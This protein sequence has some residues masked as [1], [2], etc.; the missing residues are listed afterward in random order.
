MESELIQRIEKAGQTHLLK[1][2]DEL[3]EQ[4]KQKYIETLKTID[5]ENITE[6]TKIQPQIK[7]D[8]KPF[9]NIESVKSEEKKVWEEKGFELLSQNKGAVLMLA[10]G[11][12][13]RLGF[14]HPKGMYD[15]GLPSHH[16]LFQLQTERLLTLQ[17]LVNRKFNTN[18]HIPLIIMTNESNENEIREYY[19]KNKYFGL[20]KD[21][22]YFFA[23]GML[24]AVDFNGKIIMEDKNVISLSPNG[25]GGVYRGLYYSGIIEQLEK[26]G[27]EYIVQTAVDN[28][29]NKMA[30][31]VLI[32]YMSVKGYDCCAKVLPKK[33][34]TEAVGVLALKNDQPTVI[35]YSE[36]TTE[37]AHETN[38]KGELKYNASHICNNGYALSFLKKIGNTYLPFHIAKKKIPFLN[39]NGV[40]EQ[41]QENNGMKFEMFIFDAFNLANKMG[42]LE[43][44]REEEFAPLKNSDEAQVDCPKTCRQMIYNQSRRWLEAVGARL[45][46]KRS[47]AIEISYLMTYNGENLEIFRNVRITLPIFL[48]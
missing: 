8:I 38:E 20:E 33:S 34:P 10:G 5:Y 41:P 45:D 28:V 1:Y 32:G 18:A 39:D 30:D 27:V 37:M 12:G 29:L 24:P 36:I 23:Q 46:D 16:T 31:P 25:N 13:S 19:E 47:N 3:D 42:A 11:Q 2:I 6:L 14:E 4:G 48:N 35:E 22:V 15:L 9:E 40:V 26:R 43:V 7:G 44:L 17:K 21:D